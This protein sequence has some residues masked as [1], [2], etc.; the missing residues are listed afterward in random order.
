VERAGLAGFVDRR[1]RWR[2]WQRELVEIAERCRK[3]TMGEKGT[4]RKVGSE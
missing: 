4:S 2:R 3:E 1:R